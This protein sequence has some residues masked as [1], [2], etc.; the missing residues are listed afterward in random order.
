MECGIAEC[1][2]PEE[3]VKTAERSIVRQLDSGDVVGRCASGLRL[4]NY[5][6][7]RN[8]YGLRLLV[9]ESGDEPRACDAI[10]LRALARDPFHLGPPFHVDCWIDVCLCRFRVIL[11]GEMHRS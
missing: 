3:R 6:L 5:L 11:S 4:W 9:D 2:V 1:V 10:N 7:R 8:K